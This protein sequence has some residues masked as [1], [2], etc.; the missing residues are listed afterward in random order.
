MQNWNIL[1]QIYLS[2]AQCG[3]GTTD[4]TCY[5]IFDSSPFQPFM[6][7]FKPYAVTNTIDSLPITLVCSVHFDNRH[8]FFSY[9]N[10]RT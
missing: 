3:K 1:K 5:P 7:V 6:E 4:L 9:S 8:F 10:H 2:T